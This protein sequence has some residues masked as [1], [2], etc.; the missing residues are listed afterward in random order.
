VARA[1]IA[2]EQGRREIAVEPAAAPGGGWRGQEVRDALGGAQA[3][4]AADAAEAPGVEKDAGRVEI[5]LGVQGEGGRAGVRRGGGDG[6]GGRDGGEDA[7]RAEVIGGEGGGAGAHG[8]LDAA[9]GAHQGGDA[10]GGGAAGGDHHRTAQ[11]H[12]REVGRAGE[13]G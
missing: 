1:G 4:V 6:G 8:E 2:E 10:Q 7:D 3:A 11:L 13:A 5:A 9:G 12:L